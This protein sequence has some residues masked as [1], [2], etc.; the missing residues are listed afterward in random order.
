M[1]YHLGILY[2]K[3]DKRIE[4]NSRVKLVMDYLQQSNSLHSIKLTYFDI[5]DNFEFILHTNYIKVWISA[6]NDITPLI[7]LY[8]GN[9][10]QTIL[11]AICDDKFTQKDYTN[12]IHVNNSDIGQVLQLLNIVF[13]YTNKYDG[14]AAI[15][16]LYVFFDNDNASYEKYFR[17][18]ENKYNLKFLPITYCN[19]DN[20]IEYGSTV[21]QIAMYIS[22]GIITNINTLFIYL[23][24]D[25]S[26]FFKIYTTVENPLSIQSDVNITSRIRHICSANAY[27][28]SGYIDIYNLMKEYLL[29]KEPDFLDN[30]CKTESELNTFFNKSLRM[31]VFAPILSRYEI[32]K[33]NYLNYVLYIKNPVSS[34][35]LQNNRITIYTILLE[36][37]LKIGSWLLYRNIPELNSL[38]TKGILLDGK[39]FGPPNY[40]IT[41]NSIDDYWYNRIPYYTF[42]PNILYYITDFV[43]KT[44]YN[45]KQSSFMNKNTNIIQ[46]GIYIY[47][48]PEEI[49]ISLADGVASIAGNNF[50]I[51]E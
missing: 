7:D 1:E 13:V 9:N 26:V 4:N 43:N 41:K 27:L 2:N 6:M 28:N 39:L 30:F 14:D 48:E 47:V 17:L 45:A 23:T 10:P 16:N 40:I 20:P 35:F 19:T 51:N 34:T 50:V 3:N 32:E 36:K 37:A 18:N 15:T 44:I 8:F 25:F 46:G 49:P 22:E 21:S 29:P 11:I 38:R 24:R 42:E 31:T 33:Y 5:S 12:I